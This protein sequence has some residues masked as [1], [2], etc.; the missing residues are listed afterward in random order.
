[1]PLIAPGIPEFDYLRDAPPTIVG[2]LDQSG[3]TVYIQV[4]KNGVQVPITSSG[5]VEIGNTGSYAWSTSN[6]PV[7]ADVR[8]QYYYR[9]TS[10]ALE[11]EGQFILKSAES[12][13]IM[14]SLND[15]SS[16]L[17]TII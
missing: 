1:M 11:D 9:F 7:I 5:T 17:K 6:L 10:G 2:D 8:E 13:D 16:F 3:L 15:G 4:F 14:P 12:R